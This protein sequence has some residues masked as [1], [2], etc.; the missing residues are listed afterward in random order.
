MGKNMDLIAFVKMLKFTINLLS[1]LWSKWLLISRKML[2]MDWVQRVPFQSYEI[3]MVW[4]WNA[5]NVEKW[6]VS[7]IANGRTGAHS[8]RNPEVYMDVCY[9]IMVIIIIIFIR[10]YSTQKEHKK[11]SVH[12]QRLC[13]ESIK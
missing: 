1:I 9:D 8:N 11:G 7:I 3:E 4:G 6:N 10:T 5:E 2:K 12:V 13:R